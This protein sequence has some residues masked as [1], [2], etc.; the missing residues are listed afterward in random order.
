M[1]YKES[2]A[3]WLT[4]DGTEE[5]RQKVYDLIN[6]D[7][8]LSWI[9]SPQLSEEGYLSDEMLP[10]KMYEVPE[11]FGCVEEWN[12]EEQE[13]ILHKI[14]LEVPNAT[15]TL[16]G[17][18]VASRHSNYRFKK[19]FRG[20]LFQEVYQLSFLPELTE[21]GFIPFDKRLEPVPKPSLDEV[22]KEYTEKQ[23]KLSASL[24]PS[25]NTPDKTPIR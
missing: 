23:K 25:L 12:E 16:E 15:L 20:E 13:K 8:D 21:D 3:Y 14:A 7:Y 24:S 4:V 18:C 5:D 11:C 9:L 19:Q 17:E 6:S 2:F 10:P 1:S 22:V